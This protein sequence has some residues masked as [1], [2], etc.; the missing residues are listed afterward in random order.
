MNSQR[1]NKLVI[2]IIALAL[3]AVM[4]PAQVTRV[5]ELEFPPLPEFEIPQPARVV[6]DN[7]IVL[8]VLEDRELPLV[9]ATVLVKTGA[10]LEPAD[11]IGLASLTGTVM[12]TGGTR[13]M[14]G[15]ELDD[16]LEGKAAR[17]EVSIGES[18]GTASMSCLRQDFQEVFQVLE[19]V[20]RRPAFE[21]SKLRVAKNQAV[22]TIARRNDSPQGILFREFQKIVFGSDS[23]Y[24]RSS[25]YATIGAI[26]RE[27]L[28]DWHRRYFH[29]NRMIIGLVGD[30][31]TAEA[32][33]MVKRVLGDWER[34]PEPQPVEVDYNEAVQPGVYYVE[35]SD[36]T[37]S[38]IIMGHLG[39][40][41]NNPDYY[42]VEV[43]N[44]VLSGTMAS[45]LFSSVRTEK[46]LAY[47]VSGGV[48]S[49]WDRP[50]TFNMWMTTKTETTGAGIEALQ[51]EA[52][53]LTARPPT[54][55]EVAKAKTSILN[56]FIFNSDTKAKIL[57]QQ[58]T[59]EYYGYPLD[60]LARYRQGIEQVTVEEVREAAGEYVHPDRF[61]ILVVGPPEGQDRPLSEF[62]TVT[63]VD[64][65]IPEGEAAGP[66]AQATPEAA[67]QGQALVSKAVQ[68]IGGE[69]SLDAIDSLR[70][71]GVT[72]ANTP[73]GELA[74]DMVLIMDF[75]DRLRQEVTLPFGKMI[76]VYTPKDSFAITPSGTQ[77]LPEAQAA[78]FRKSFH[79]Q[80]IG[81]LKL[82]KDP[83]FS[84][85]LEGN[86]EV[87]GTPVETVRVE[88]RG[89][90][91]TLAI[92][93]TNGRILQLTYRGQN[94]QG[95]P[96]EVVQTFAD[97][98]EVQGL[99]VPFRSVNTFNG[100][101]L[102]STEL[103]EL[104]IDAPAQE[105]DFQRP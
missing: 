84:A 36:M 59:Y 68:G 86:G 80:Q 43:L 22:S 8:M 95:V 10:R 73:Q 70:F 96:G 56:S 32:V 71:R 18:S 35:K 51:D 14:P 24:A 58:L 40:V 6:L 53:D 89:E 87:G 66:G 3:S 28:V 34:G 13:N 100:E 105:K 52:R 88:V 45:R 9:N 11:Q 42:A 91:L 47:S 98:R 46:G 4:L 99:T 93:P 81:L 2:M 61:A 67:A 27:D 5:E 101:P 75:P 44:Q 76:M 48:G 72:V 64:I 20:L 85:V 29:P 104:T 17:I 92:D 49:G 102:L 50:G 79:R 16:Y 30:F 7:G 38:N 1:Q 103:Q 62:G 26:Q 21:E 39:I 97:F 15:D 25:T 55:E 60:W 77:P 19:D 41:R 63:P 57:G 83:G 90:R 33:E 82:R 37:Q 54:E 78:E 23:P 65:S 69:A 94:M 12:R 31:E 74:L